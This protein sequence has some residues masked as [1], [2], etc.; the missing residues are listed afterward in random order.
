VATAIGTSIDAAAIGVTLALIGA[1]ILLVALSIGATTFLLATLGLRL[2]GMEG[3]RLG[4]AVE[5]LG[6]IALVVLG[7]RI[8]LEHLGML[9]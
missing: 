2:G 6:G 9:G 7:T 5:M 1:N 3:A 8:L 4:S